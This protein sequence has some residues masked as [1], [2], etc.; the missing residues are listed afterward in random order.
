[1][2]EYLYNALPF[3]FPNGQN[4]YKHLT[5]HEGFPFA[6]A[7]GI[8]A[9]F[10]LLPDLRHGFGLGRGTTADGW[11]EDAVRFWEKYIFRKNGTSYR[12]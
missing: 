4:T 11:H 5:I 3:F 12:K 9:E 10:H 7:L 2:T 6:I 1:M 8:D